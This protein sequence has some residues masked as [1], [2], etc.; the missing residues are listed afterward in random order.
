M[1]QVHRAD[2]ALEMAVS[3]AQGSEGL[4]EALLLFISNAS[5]CGVISLLQYSCLPKIHISLTDLW[6]LNSCLTALPQKGFLI[7]GLKKQ[8]VT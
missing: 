5:R 4:S 7:L 8:P 2:S 1:E 6:V 3:L